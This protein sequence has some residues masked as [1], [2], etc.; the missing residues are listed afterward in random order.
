MYNLI[1]FQKSALKHKLSMIKRVFSM[2]PSKFMRLFRINELH[3]PKAMWL[4]M[5]TKV[6]INYRHRCI[7]KCGLTLLSS[8]GTF[9]WSGSWTRSAM[10]NLREMFSGHLISLPG[11]IG[12]PS[13]SP[14][15]N[16]RSFFLWVY[17]KSIH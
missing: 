14:D 12:W 15:L 1:K 5:L 13:R 8:S 16:L 6:F 3:W 7:K 10:G 9:F 11:D 17:L 4:T 2:R